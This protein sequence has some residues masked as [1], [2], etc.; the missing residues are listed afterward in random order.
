MLFHLLSLGFVKAILQLV[1]QLNLELV[2]TT[3]E[4]LFAG[5]LGGGHYGHVFGVLDQQGIDQVVVAAELTMHS[6]NLF[7]IC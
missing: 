4:E 5:V 7:G 6:H 3:L 1:F 2:Q